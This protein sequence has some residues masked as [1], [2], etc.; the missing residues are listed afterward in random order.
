LTGRLR[1]SRSLS[2]TAQ[3]DCA[4]EFPREE[5]RRCLRRVTFRV[6][7]HWQKPKTEANKREPTKESD[8][9][10]LLTSLRVVLETLVFVGV[11]ESGGKDSLPPSQPSLARIASELRL[12][13]PSLS[14]ARNPSAKLPYPLRC[15]RRAEDFPISL[16]QPD[17][18]PLLRSIRALG[19]ERRTSRRAEGVIRCGMPFSS[20]SRPSA[21]S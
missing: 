11:S 18:C 7:L 17:R 13:K 8:D 5:L 16:E 14:S 1:R 3:G 4:C 10:N 20:C 6:S 2:G 12:G 19:P 9:A 15:R 21:P